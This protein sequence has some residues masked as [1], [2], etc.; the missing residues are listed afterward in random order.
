MRPAL[1]CSR[2]AVS[3]ITVS[4]PLSTPCCT[5]S[6]AT[7][8]GSVASAPRTTSTPDPLAPGG[9]LVDGRGAERV[10]G[11][12]RHGAV[13]GDQDPGQLADRGGLAGAVDTDH[14]DDARLAVGAADL[15]PAVHGRVDE[16]D[17]LRAERGPRVLGS[18]LDPEPGA[19]PVDHL[20]GGP[21]PEVG[22]EQDVLDRLPGVLVELLAA[23]QRE[24][25]AA[26]AALRSGQPLPQPDQ[27][28]GGRL[29]LLDR[30][31]RRGALRRWRLGDGP[32]GARRRQSVSPGLRPRTTN[33]ITAPI[34]TT[35][36]TA[37]MRIS[38]AR[39]DM[40]PSN[41][42]AAV[43]NQRDADSAAEQH[44]SALRIV[45]SASA[46]NRSSRCPRRGPPAGP[47]L[48]PVVLLLGEHRD[49]DERDDHDQDHHD[50][51]RG[52]ACQR[53]RAHK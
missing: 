31:G 51:D 6:K 1:F 16:R 20:L 28:G 39:E 13:L 19:Q 44:Q 4:T 27:P 34:S 24:Q 52:H 48:R 49:D 40:P 43:A 14:E 7:L 17:E 9:E 46:P 32:A 45:D 15:Q 26:E 3:M 21:D 36:T 38:S 35:A 11:P 18:A 5:A 10:G 41:Q 30:G 22:G 37:M 2:P 42:D 50:Q 23:E 53:S 33:P 25:P 8:A 29:R 12:E 47:L